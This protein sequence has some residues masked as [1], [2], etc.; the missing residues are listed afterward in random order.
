MDVDDDVLE[1]AIRR[2]PA[3]AALSA[4]SRHRQALQERLD[5]SKATCHRILRSFEEMRLLRRTDEGYALTPLGEEVA[6]QVE[7]FEGSVRSAY[8]LEPLLWAFE[9][10]AVD[11]DVKPF[12]NAT[13]T[14][15]E[16]DDPSPPIHRYLELFREARSVRTVARTSFVPPLYLEEIFETAFDDDK[17][18]G[19]VIYPKSVVEN[20]YAEYPDWHRQVATAGIPIRYRVYERAPFGLTI[21]DDDHV[22]L[23]AYDED[24][25]TLVLF[26]DS[27]D[28]E[29][30]AWAEDA[31]DEYYER[32][33]PLSAFEEFPDWVPDSEVSDVIP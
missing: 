6:E 8:R 18:G 12:T 31:F 9:S 10:A 33:E 23:R 16:P 32:S 14:R 29:A 19:I 11:F 13:I 3:L 28:P 22:G 5:V 20:R 1:T 21:F 27:D 30:V 25:G 15:P 2:K 4:E 7:A 17:K 24:T 26:V